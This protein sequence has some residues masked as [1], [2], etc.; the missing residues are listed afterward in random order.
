MIAVT[1]RVTGTRHVGVEV[2][3]TT[4]IDGQYRDAELKLDAQLVNAA[5]TLELNLF[6]ANNKKMLSISKPAADSVR[7]GELPIGL[8]HGVALTVAVA[9][10]QPLHW[11]DVA[12]DETT[13]AARTRREMEAAFAPSG[14]QSATG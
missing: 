8:A 12:I 7:R 1:R 5:G 11:S 10:D 4:D 2:A 9:A 3:I 14:T 13:I 6:D